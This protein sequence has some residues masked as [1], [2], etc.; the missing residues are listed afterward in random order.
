[1]TGDERPGV[2][3]LTGATG[4]IGGALARRLVGTGWR[5]RALVRSRSRAEA[6]RRLGVELVAGDLEDSR[7]IAALVDGARAVAHC[8][9]TVRGVAEADFREA[10][11]KGLTRLAQTAARREPPPRFI[12]V[13][14]LAAREPRLSPYAASKRA[15]EDGLAAAAGAMRWIAL[16]PPAVYGPGDREMLPLLRLMMR[17]VAPVLG[18]ADARFSLLYV[19]DLV[20]AVERCLGATEGPGG[21]FELHDGR[22]GGYSWN[23]VVGIAAGLRGRPV[24]VVRMPTALLGWLGRL[25]V[26]AAR[27]RRHPPMLTPGKVRELTHPDWVCDNRAFTQ[28]YGWEPSVDFREG[29]RRTLGLSAPDLKAAA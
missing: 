10:N 12:A 27:L 13:S 26:A 18:P 1:M 20:A 6:L 22:P 25:N 29:L 8:A 21:T 23:D 2:V 7:A 24:R 5:V 19:D 16:R 15:G 3:A 28:A 11:L 17:G 14:S 4:F 9:G